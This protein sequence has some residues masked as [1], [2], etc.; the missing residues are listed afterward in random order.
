VVGL[1]IC[2][3]TQTPPLIFHTTLDSSKKSIGTLS[4]PLEL[5][6]HAED[7]D[8][9]LSPGG[10]TRMVLPLLRGMADKGILEQAHWVSLSPSGPQHAILNG[11]HLHHIS[12]PERKM[13]GYGR[14]KEAFWSTLHG[15]TS[16]GKPTQVLWQDAF[17]DYTFYNRTT[18]QE[19]TQ[20]D[21][22]FDFDLFYIHDFQQ[23]AVGHML[24]TLKP[25]I[26]RWHIPFDD[27]TIPKAWRE[28]FSSYL[29]GYDTV[30]VS[31]E[32]YL[33][34]LKRLGYTGDAHYVYPYIDPKPYKRLTRKKLQEFCRRFRL[35]S[36]DDVILV[37][38]RLDPM[39]GQDKALIAVG[40]VVEE[41]PNVKLLLVG[42][43][44]FS[45]SK[46]G[47]GLSKAV[48]WLEKLKSLAK[49]LGIEDNVVYTGH[50]SQEDLNAAYQRSNLTMLPSIRE[51][52]GL[53]VIESWL[54]HKPT[55]VT[56]NAGIAELIDDGE[57][58]LLVNPEDSDDFAEKI[59]L[60][61]RSPTR[62]KKL[63]DNGYASSKK[64]LISEG[65]KTESRLIRELV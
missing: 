27:A 17:S 35:S 11:I 39:K 28:Y 45:S 44:S 8:Y 2:V 43:G 15:E 29:N 19:I 32:K 14:T 48:K 30:I 5:D 23:L 16:T 20:L 58:G 62:A 9:H 59:R 64:C 51:G 36:E 42:N 13:E 60:L 47:I 40:K 7:K 50:V 33:E 21:H 26:F 56:R 34:P 41:A 37:V 12:L 57:N 53:V 55:I 3:N 31:S 6:P 24:R 25:K 22:A 4:K 65:V 1:R 54:F 18:A 52:F 63:A 61:L 49:R 38:A 10:V 46:E